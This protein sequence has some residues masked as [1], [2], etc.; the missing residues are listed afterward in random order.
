MV[1]MQSVIDV[2]EALTAEHERLLNISIEKTDLIKAGKIDAIQKI[3]MQERKQTQVIS[4]LETKRLQ[5][6]DSLFDEMKINETD[7]TV[8]VLLIHMEGNQAK[9]NMEA[10][11]AQLIDIIV[12]IRDVE[13][14]NK[15]LLQQSMTFVQLSL[16]MFQPNIEQMNYGQKQTSSKTRGTSVFD[17]KA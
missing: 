13:Q 14:L 6:V 17:S 3:L 9:K 16:G 7:R 5:A 4:Q 12:Q 15:E 10:A 8:S 1:T 11:V 2:I